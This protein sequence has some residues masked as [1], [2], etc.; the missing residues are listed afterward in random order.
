MRG[1][2][3]TFMQS[4]DEP[5]RHPFLESAEGLPEVDNRQYKVLYMFESRRLNNMTSPTVRELGLYLHD[6]STSQVR[7]TVL[8]L[9]NI[10]YLKPGEKK[11]TRGA[12]IGVNFLTIEH[13]Q[14]VVCPDEEGLTYP[15]QIKQFINHP[16][17][18]QL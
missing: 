12:T 7:A 17:D 14:G 9:I 3:E 1:E 6:K 8:K 2:F 16:Q 4:D 15:R 5:I 13:E 10:G 18:P 11:K